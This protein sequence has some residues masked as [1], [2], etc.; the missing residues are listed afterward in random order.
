M[1]QTAIKSKDVKICEKINTSTKKE[2]C[3]EA[4]AEYNLTACLRVEDITKSEECI[5]KHAIMLNSTEICI[6]IK[7]TSVAKNCRETVDPC[8][9]KVGTEEKTCKSLQKRDYNLCYKEQDCLYKY[10][11]ATGD[12]AACG[13]LSETAEQFACIGIVKNED[14]CSKLS[15]SSQVDNCRYI[16]AVRTDNYLWCTAT[17]PDSMYATWCY[18]H[19]ASKNNTLTICDLGL[20]LDNRW[21]CYRN[22]SIENRNITGCSNINKLATSGLFNCFWSY[23]KLYGDASA[24]DLMNDTGFRYSCYVGAIMNNTQLNYRYCENVS[25]VEWKNKCHM[26]SAKNAKNETICNFIKTD[27]EKQGCIGVVQAVKQ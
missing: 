24:C 16:Y 12:I 13:L 7:N 17:T 8:Y 21:D 18:S 22:Y 2:Q 3:Y 19:F 27:L 6:N 20:S 25:V 26:Q 5:G 23:A 15:I 14:E 4:L 10:A 11:K 1:V 9:Y